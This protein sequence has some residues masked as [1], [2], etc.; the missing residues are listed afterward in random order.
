MTQSDATARRSA[1]P[2]WGAVFSMTLCVAMLIASEFMPVSLLSPMAKGLGA[3]EGATGQAISISGLFAVA[4][5]LAITTFAGQMN[6][7]TVLIAMTLVML[8][9]LVLIA[10]A[11]NF[12]VLM[13]ARALLGISVGGFWALGTSVLM[14]LVPQDKVAAAL[15]IMYTGQASAA[16]FA[17][18]L[19]SYLGG[20]IG[21]RGVF[22]LLVPIVII[23]VIWQM[24]TL[25]S[26]PARGRQSFAAL[27]R[28]FK[29]SYFRR[30]I[31]AV[32]FTWGG[33]FTMFTY[34]RP[35]LEG[36]TGADVDTLSLLLLVLGC[37]GFPGS[38]AAGRLANAHALRINQLLPLAMAAV[39]IALLEFGVSAWAS[40]VLL[41]LWGALN[42]AMSITWMTWVSQNL[43]DEAEAAGSVMV[44][45]IQTAILL[46]AA[47]GG[48]LLDHLG[49]EY[50]FICSAAFSFIAFLAVGNGKRLR[51]T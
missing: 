8:A 13:A 14:R 27:P 42:T 17:A 11:P 16:A 46:G 4:A 20:M 10:I 45:S 33:A 36:V 24:V 31:F 1:A 41:V 28:L 32:V 7:K 2:A 51:R 12:A 19:G 6:R 38:W 26:L 49:I 48:Y 29:R 47:I 9:S 39:T 5:S 25:P 21:W 3:S 40:A 18:P 22:W 34:L 43:T 30:G 44:A 37:A 50:T 15:G 23:D 35:F